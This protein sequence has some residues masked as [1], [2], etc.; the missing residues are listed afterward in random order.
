MI[1]PVTHLVNPAT[2]LISLLLIVVT[3]AVC[4]HYTRLLKGR[5]AIQSIQCVTVLVEQI[6]HMYKRENNISTVRSRFKSETT[7]GLTDF[8]PMTEIQSYFLCI[9]KSRISSYSIRN[10]DTTQNVFQI[11]YQIIARQCLLFPEVKV[12]SRTKSADS[13][14]HHKMTEMILTTFFTSTLKLN[15]LFS[16]LLKPF[17]LFACKYTKCRRFVL[18]S[19]SSSKQTM[20]LHTTITNIQLQAEVS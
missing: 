1:R 9:K 3:S 12:A 6:I 14:F 15:T 20:I 11:R 8:K 17:L 5:A 10:M 13:I 4:L 7:F 19:L 18:L 2:S 16:F